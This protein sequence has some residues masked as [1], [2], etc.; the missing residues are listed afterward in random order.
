M[1]L[2][3]WVVKPTSASGGQLN[4]HTSRVS[5]D[6]PQT[7]SQTASSASLAGV[8]ALQPVSSTELFPVEASEIEGPI[9]IIPQPDTATGPLED[10]L[11]PMILL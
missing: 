11:T 8:N 3:R 5:T 1:S 6:E 4:S 2:L 7:E 10:P 9:S